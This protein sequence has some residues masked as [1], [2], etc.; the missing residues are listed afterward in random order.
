MQD[1]LLHAVIRDDDAS[2]LF[3]CAVFRL[4]STAKSKLSMFGQGGI[5]GEVWT[6]TKRKL[7]AAEPAPRKS[8]AALLRAIGNVKA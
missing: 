7:P 1:E 4:V 6:E 8:D 3:A 2:Y 5:D